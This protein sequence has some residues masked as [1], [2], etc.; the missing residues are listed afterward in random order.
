MSFLVDRK[1]GD[2][3]RKKLWN[4][5]SEDDRQLYMIEADAY[6]DCIPEDE[7]IDFDYYG[8][9]EEMAINA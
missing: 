4:Q 7:W 3:T 5:L 1:E 9:T 2:Y 8:V 6:F